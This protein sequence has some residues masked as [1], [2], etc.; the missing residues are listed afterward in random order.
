MSGRWG[1]KAPERGL[2][3]AP[4]EGGWGA[5]S[6]EGSPGGEGRQLLVWGQDR[7]NRTLACSAVGLDLSNGSSSLIL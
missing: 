6:E 3:R 5:D 2:I 7:I 4:R 1:R